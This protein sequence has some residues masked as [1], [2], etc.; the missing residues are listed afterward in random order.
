M[1]KVTNKILALTLAGLMAGI[2]ACST[3]STS[4]TTASSASETTAAETTAAESSEETS[5]ETTAASE[6]TSEAEATTEETS[7]ATEAT[8]AAESSAIT[9]VDNSIPAP[10]RVL[11]DDYCNAIKNG[12][13]RDEGAMFENCDIYANNDKKDTA[14]YICK[15]TGDEDMMKDFG[16]ELVD[17]DRDGRDELI[18]GKIEP[19]TTRFQSCAYT[20]D[21]NGDVVRLFYSWFKS[22]KNVLDDS[23]IVEDA[24]MSSD[25]CI[26][27]HYKLELSQMKFIDALGISMTDDGKYYYYADDSVDTLVNVDIA[28]GSQYQ[29]S[30]DEIVDKFQMTVLLDTH[31][32]SFAEYAG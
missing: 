23:T 8:D 6:E 11:I 3:T 13:E 26:T 2:T 15:E 20:I 14:I 28:P 18:V 24:N 27:N 1:K 4:D 21:D 31:Y 7:A 30:E 5:A 22:L 9:S 12:E 25:F 17:L 19:A 32:I 16:F 10:Y 29:I